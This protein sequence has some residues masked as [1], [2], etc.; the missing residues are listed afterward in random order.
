M[1]FGNL[2]HRILFAKP[3]GTVTNG[4]GETVPAYSL[5]HPSLPFKSI[6]YRKE[7]WQDSSGNIVNT[8]DNEYCIWADVSPLTSREYTNSQK[9]RAETT[10]RIRV[11]FLSGIERDMLI[12]YEDKKLFIQSVLEKD[13][14]CKELE[15]ICFEVNL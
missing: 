12:L 1:R 15:I 10:Y 4:M 7:N 5:Y 2:R 3:A 6:E 9:L 14:K 8:I 11:R 13:T